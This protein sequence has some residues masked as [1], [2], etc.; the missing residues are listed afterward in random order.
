[1]FAVSL[2]VRGKEIL[3]FDSSRLRSSLRGRGSAARQQ[4]RWGEILV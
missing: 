1:M 4:S 3:V 2:R